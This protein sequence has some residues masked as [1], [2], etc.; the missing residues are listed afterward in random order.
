MII[1]N[2]LF[3]L[4]YIQSYTKPYKK[5]FSKRWKASP[6]EG[7]W[8]SFQFLGILEEGSG[9]EEEWRKKEEVK[10]ESTIFYLEQFAHLD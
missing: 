5:C 6:H 4:F 7:F 10:K 2:D 1:I 8:I 3:S 9:R